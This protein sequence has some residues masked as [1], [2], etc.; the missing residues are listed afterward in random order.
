MKGVKTIRDIVRPT[1][2]FVY[3]RFK[4]SLR[5]SDYGT[6]KEATFKL[7]SVDKD[8]RARVYL[9]GD[10]TNNRV[11]LCYD[12]KHDEWSM[13]SLDENCKEKF[14]QCSASIAMNSR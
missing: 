3:Y 13:K 6:A 2:H 7:P 4:D 9:F 5:V 8:Y 11:S 12:I 14:N 10:D 1:P